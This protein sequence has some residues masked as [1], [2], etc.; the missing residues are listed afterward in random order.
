[1]KIRFKTLF[2]I[3]GM[4]LAL[5]CCN[6]PNDLIAIHKEV[7]ALAEEDELIKQRVKSLG[8]SINALQAI[9][10]VLQSGYY[11]KSVTPFTDADGRTGNICS[12]TN[13]TE[14]RIYDGVDGDD[15]RVP[16]IGVQEGADG[17]WYWTLD[18][19]LIQDDKGHPVPVTDKPT[20]DETIKDASGMVPQLTI[21][22][23]YW[24]I[25]FDYGET[26][27]Q[28][29]QAT[30]REGLDGDDAPDQVISIDQTSKD[31][32]SFVLQDGTTLSV[33]YYKEIRIHFSSEDLDVPIGGRETVRIDYTLTASDDE[34]YVSVSSDGFYTAL[35]RQ[36]SDLEGYILVTCPRAY[37]DGYINV[38]VYSKLGVSDMKVINFCEKKMSFSEGCEFEVPVSGGS[39]KVPFVTNFDYKVEVDQNA[40]DW[41]AIVQ[42]KAS[43]EVSGEIVI[44]ASENKGMARSG[45]VNVYSANGVEPFASIVITQESPNCKTDKG[46][47]VVSYEGGTVL[48]TITTSHGASLEIPSDGWVRGQVN[49]SGDNEYVIVFT[50]DPNASSESREMTVNVNSEDG[51][52]PLTKIQLVQ[53]G[54]NIDLEMAMIFIVKPN[55]SNDFTAYLPIDVSEWIGDWFGEFLPSNLDCFIDWGDGTKGEHIS[56]LDRRWD[57]PE[58][59]RAIR[60]HYEGLE[61]GKEF[62]VVITGTVPSLNAN[63]IPDAYKSSVTEVKQWGSLGL[64]RMYEAFKGFTGLE[65]LHPDETGAFSEVSTFHGAFRDCPRLKTVSE[66]LFDYA[67]KAED[68]GELFFRCSALVSIPANLFS[69][70]ESAQSF[71]IAF[72]ECK[73]LLSIPEELFASCPK[74]KYMDQ[75]FRDCHSVRSIPAGLFSKCQQ[76]EY[77]DYSFQGCSSISVIPEDLFKNNREAKAFVQ[78]FESF[79]ITEVPEHLFDNCPDVKSFSGIFMGCRHLEDVPCSLFDNQRKVIDFTRTFQSCGMRGETP[80]T[81]L[82]DGTKVHLYERKDHPDAFVTPVYYE[83]CFSDCWNLPDWEDIPIVWRIGR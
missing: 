13:G 41:L 8:E 55:Y 63:Y 45:I 9:V 31:Y 29:G 16:Q 21:K 61:V 49:A 59:E 65:T 73:S 12:F 78:T 10:D 51:S 67:T 72:A 19:S 69:R 71:S 28:L 44:D 62:E 26:W 18:G 40:A 27:K 30:G 74:V 83:D 52:L 68:F 35:S 38:M 5:T 64:K 24:F 56:Y 43:E 6:I 3:L 17:K 46:S 36:T 82:D 77:F 2:A 80:Y 81:V 11:I 7:D 32:V 57:L 66:H 25:S 20:G 34:T 1:M 14:I 42:T 15:G 54:R 58:A 47:H 22:G 33:P 60:H 23:G 39:V 4:A 70:C 37:S 76:V 50:V 53:R 79:A 48:T 75:V